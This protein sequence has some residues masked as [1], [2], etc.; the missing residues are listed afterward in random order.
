MGPPTYD[1]FSDGCYYF[2]GYS[3]RH[4]FNKSDIESALNPTIYGTYG[5]HGSKCFK[6]TVF[7]RHY[8]TSNDSYLRCHEPVCDE[9]NNISIKIA[10][11]LYACDKNS[12][13]C[14]ISTK[15]NNANLEGTVTLP[16][17]DWSV[18]C[19]EELTPCKNFCSKKGYCMKNKCH[20]L[21][22]YLGD[23]CSVTCDGYFHNDE[24][25]S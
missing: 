23:D 4:C 21:P 7:H 12:N 22:G 10:G 20:C 17:R 24:C 18:F 3:N 2:T 5:G 13:T 19:N 16:Y 9:N 25:V 15:G 14:T 6:S 11:E 8:S 1:T